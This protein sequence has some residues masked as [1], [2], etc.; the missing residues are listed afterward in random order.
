MKIDQ[1]EKDLGLTQARL[2]GPVVVGVVR[3]SA[4]LLLQNGVDQRY[5]EPRL[6]VM[7]GVIRQW[8]TSS[9][10]RASVVIAMPKTIQAT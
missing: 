1:R 4:V 5:Y 10:L 7:L 6:G 8:I 2:R 3:G 9:R